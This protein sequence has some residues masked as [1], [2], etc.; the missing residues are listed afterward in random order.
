MPRRALVL[1]IAFPFPDSGTG[2]L[3]REL[4]TSRAPIN[5]AAPMHQSRWRIRARGGWRRPE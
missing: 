3:A 5:K 1:S 2:A 4:H